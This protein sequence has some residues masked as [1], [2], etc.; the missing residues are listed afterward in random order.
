MGDFNI[1]LLKYNYCNF[2]TEFF[3]QFSSSG[4]MPLITKPTRITKS[5]ATLID[6]FTN[7]LSKMEHLNGILL[8]DISD[9]FPIFTVTEHELQDCP[10]TPKIDDCTTQIIT[11]ES[12]E[13][14]CCE[15]ENCNW[16][17]TL[18]KN[19]PTESYT[20]FFKDFFEL[21]DKF[22]PMKKYKRSNNLWISKGLKK[23]SKTKEVLF[24]KFIKNPSEK[25]ERDY[26]IYQNKLNHLTR[27]AKKNYY[28]K[29]LDQAG[30][31]IKSTWNTINELLGRVKSKSRLPVSFLNNNNEEVCDS[32]LIA[33]DFND[34]FVNIGPNL[35][36][37]FNQGSDGFYK[38]LK[39]SY[40]DSMF[41]YDASH[42][43][44]HKVIDK[45]ASKSSCGIDEISCKVIKC[46]APYISVPLSYIF[47]LTFATGK[48]PDDLKVALVTPVYKESEENI[49]SNYRPNS[50][51]PCFSKILE[52]L[53][54]KRFIDYIHKNRILTDCQ[55]GFRSNI[56]TNHAIIELV[57][58]NNHNK[59]H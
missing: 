55:Y 57:N 31:D 48:I 30:N 29:R 50:V 43:E 8:N 44:V 46:V 27:L 47:N 11:K 6:I 39:G 51:L 26:K 1:D 53:M 33:N 36:K 56:S 7:N 35:A 17:S 25:N 13:A 52:K 2:S 37:K 34:Y 3:N 18:S 59:S 4:Y 15:I 38:F 45:M 12:L 16:Q 49:Y 9:H 28:S 5:T 20:A 14:F 24:R 42:D 32:K 54:Y 10:K 41:L 21:Y 40:D 19:D 58:K 23:S 22:F